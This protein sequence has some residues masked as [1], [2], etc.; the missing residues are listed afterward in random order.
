LR[1]AMERLGCALEL[2]R[3]FVA[4]NEVWAVALQ[5][6]KRPLGKLRVVVRR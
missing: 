6:A 2:W 4:S 3:L 1:V 5:R